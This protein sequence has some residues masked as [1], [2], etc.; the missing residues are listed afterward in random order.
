MAEVPE[1]VVKD[2][3]HPVPAGTHIEGEAFGCKLSG[4]APGAVV[5][6]EDGNG[7]AVA[8]Q[9]GCCGKSGEAG[10]NDDHFFQELRLCSKINTMCNSLFT[11]ALN[12]KGKPKPAFFIVSDPGWLIQ[13]F[14]P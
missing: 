13:P 6:F 1:E 14:L 5:F 4:S 3:G 8:R 11:Y 7:G 9:V 12:K 2:F 10:A